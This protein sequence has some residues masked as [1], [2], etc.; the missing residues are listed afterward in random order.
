MYIKLEKAEKGWWIM[1]MSVFL[2]GYNTVAM[3][4]VTTGE[5]WLKDTWD[6]SIMSYNCMCI[7]YLKNLQ[8]RS[9][10]DNNTLYHHLVF[11]NMYMSYVSIHIQTYL[12]TCTNI[13]AMHTYVSVCMYMSFYICVY[14]YMLPL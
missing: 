13:R 12:H 11:K 10:E 8:K 2:L 4:E 1:S 5:N 7:N 14:I 6:L 3:Q 9:K